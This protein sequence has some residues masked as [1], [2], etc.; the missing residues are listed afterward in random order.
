[1]VDELIVGTEVNNRNFSV[2]LDKVG[3]KGVC[4]AVFDDEKLAFSVA[5][6]CGKGI[7]SSKE[8]TVLVAGVKIG[9]LV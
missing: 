5:F 1:M 3:N 8:S 4:I 9:Q 2:V 7:V 6:Y